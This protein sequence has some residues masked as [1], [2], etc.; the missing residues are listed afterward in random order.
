M[1]KGKPVNGLDLGIWGGTIILG[2]TKQAKSLCEDLLNYSWDSRYN[3]LQFLMHLRCYKKV[4]SL[5]NKN[6]Y[7]MLMGNLTAHEHFCL[8]Y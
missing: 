2:D 7:K 8:L 1:P 6:E 3:I 4:F 5:F